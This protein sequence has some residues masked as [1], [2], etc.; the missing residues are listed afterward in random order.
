MPKRAYES[1][2]K[3][4]PFGNICTYLQDAMWTIKS[5]TRELQHHIKKT[6]KHQLPYHTAI[7]IY[8]QHIFD[9][10]ESL[11]GGGGQSE[12][13]KRVADRREMK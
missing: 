9:A 3:A 5:I 7:N 10:N 11:G 1:V 13:W 8:M 12:H 4:L 6:C 2:T